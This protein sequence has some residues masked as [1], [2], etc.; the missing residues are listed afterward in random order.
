MAGE[1]VTV[2]LA[3]FRDEVLL[4]GLWDPAKGASLTTYFVGQCILRFPNVYRSWLAHLEEYRLHGEEVL[5]EQRGD[6]AIEDEVIAHRAQIEAL[7]LVATPTP[8]RRW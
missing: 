2:A 7:R 5:H 1:V 3:P 8:A 6:W 4:P